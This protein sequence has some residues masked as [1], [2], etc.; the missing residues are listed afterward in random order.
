M[1]TANNSLRY[2]R[3][4]LRARQFGSRSLMCVL[5]PGFLPSILMTDIMATNDVKTMLIPLLN[6]LGVVGLQ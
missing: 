6:V 3:R 4:Y 2:H 5:A 1:G